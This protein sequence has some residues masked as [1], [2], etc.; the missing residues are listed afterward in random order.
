MANLQDIDDKRFEEHDE[1]LCMLCGAYGND[2][3]SLLISCFYDISELYRARRIR[4]DTGM[5]LRVP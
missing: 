2:K 5:F 3:R 1:A 4:A